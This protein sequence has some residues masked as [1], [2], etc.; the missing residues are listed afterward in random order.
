[1]AIDFLE[2]IWN[3]DKE[4]EKKRGEGEVH[5][6]YQILTNFQKKYIYFLIWMLNIENL[7]DVK[8]QEFS[9]VEHREIFRCRIS[10][11]FGYR[12]SRIFLM[13]NIETSRM[14]NIRLFGILNTA[15]FGH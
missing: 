11:N 3:N 7:V 5:L 14:S 9:D 6:L 8:H 15:N 10:R 2:L 4:K 13:L 1:M 12:I